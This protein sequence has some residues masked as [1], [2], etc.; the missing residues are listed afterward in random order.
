[1]SKRSK[2]SKRRTN[3]SVI[4]KSLKKE[5]QQMIESKK[6]EMKLVDTF[7]TEVGIYGRKSKIKITITGECSIC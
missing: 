7:S 4:L 2:R 1:M 5:R 6:K 3:S